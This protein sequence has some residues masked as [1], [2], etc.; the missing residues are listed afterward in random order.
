MKKL[1][2]ALTALSLVTLVFFSCK[3]EYSYEVPG[4]ASNGTYQWSFTEGTSNYKGPVDTAFIDTL[5]T[6]KQ[7]TIS[8][9]SSDNKDVISLQ[10]FADTIQI[11][12]YQTNRCS[13]DYLRGGAEI[14]RSDLTAIGQFTVNITAIDSISI[15]GTF[16]GIALDTARKQ[17]NIT[18][19]KFKARLK[20]KVASTP[21]TCKISKYQYT[22]SSSGLDYLSGSSAF[23]GSTMTR[24]SLTDSS[25]ASLPFPAT[26]TAGKVTFAY[27]GNS[28]KPETFTVDGSGRVSGFTGYLDPLTDTTPAV[29]AAYTYDANGHMTK[30]TQTYTPTGGTNPITLT[31]TYTWSGDLLTQGV[32]TYGTLKVAQADYEYGNT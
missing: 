17:K 22:D 29:T 19:G 18:D 30:R 5:G 28:S 8:G 23:T 1:Q 6:Q 14:Y 2:Q 7:L 16:S 20:S 15:T 24:F 26:Y 27:A 31:V 9:H 11:G 13:F 12:T 4:G 32:M 3:K 25:G 21:K 10:I